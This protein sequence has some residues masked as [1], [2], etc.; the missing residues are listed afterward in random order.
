MQARIEQWIKPKQ[1][2]KQVNCRPNLNNSY[3]APRNEVE[4]EIAD[5]WQEVLGM[6]QIGIYDNFLEIGG[7]SLLSIQITA[8]A[9][10][11]GLRF[12]NQHLFEYPTIAQLAEIA[13]NTQTVVAE[14]GLVQGELPLTPI[15]HWFFEQK[16]LDSHHWNQVVLLEVQQT[17]D[18]ALLEQVIQQLLAHHD[19]LRLRFALTESGWNQINGD[20]EAIV[21]F[22]Q[23]DLS[24]LSPQSQ[25]IAFEAA[26]QSL[27]AS[28]NLSDGPI[29]R[30]TYFNLGQ[31]QPS[32]LLFVIHHLAVDV[33]SWRI[34]LDDLHSSYQ[35]LS[36]GKAIKLPHKT[37]SFKQW[38][39]RLIEYAQSIELER[40]QV[41]WLAASRE[42]V[43]PLPTDFPDGV[44]T[45]AS[46]QTVSVTLSVEE[47][48]ALQEEITASYR[49]QM[50][51]ILLTALVQASTKWTRTR[52]LLVDLEGSS[53]KVIFDLASANFR[54]FNFIK[55]KVTRI[56]AASNYWW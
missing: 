19:A 44:N 15:Q 13:N 38:S 56:T 5:I 40:E 8:R 28:L 36:E 51:D 22:S 14:Q 50:D 48:K 43:S 11:A 16:I 26:A 45:V 49:V 21:P 20:T 32:R 47:T 25:E 42:W 1:P 3:V 33:G 52:S 6:Q 4:Q 41:Y 18:P 2:S 39:Q 55:I 9:N 17:L 10:K 12:T 23:V 37:T 7:D 34:L 27:Q 54:T 35:Q 30:I 24:A 46:A 53:R 29:I 31:H